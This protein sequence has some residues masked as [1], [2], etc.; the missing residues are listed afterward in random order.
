MAHVITASCCNDAVCAQ[1]CPV[2]CIHPTPD[3]R[4]YWTAEMLYI[5]P[6]VCIDCEAC[7]EVC[8]VAAIYRDRELPADLTT[9]AAMNAAYFEQ[10]VE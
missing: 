9:F 4:A 5:D 8:P 1:V 6:A 10:A 7:I 2:D 3:E